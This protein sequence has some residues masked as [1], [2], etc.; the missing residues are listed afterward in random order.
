MEDLL[1]GL[2]LLGAGRL[3]KETCGDHRKRF[4]SR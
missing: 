4:R 2:P 1:T 3:P